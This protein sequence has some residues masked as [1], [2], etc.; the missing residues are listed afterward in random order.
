MLVTIFILFKFED[1]VIRLSTIKRQLP[2]PAQ[3]AGMRVTMIGHNLKIS[4]DAIGISVLWDAHR[5]ISIEATAGLWNRTAGLCGT[6]DQDINNEF[7]S[8]DGT[9]LKV[10]LL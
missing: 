6:L 7:I 2:I 1:G 3:L 4:M 9:H 8:K 10:I 5:M